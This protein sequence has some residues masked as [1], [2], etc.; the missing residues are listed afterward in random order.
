MLGPEPPPSLRS[1]ITGGGDEDK[2]G[3]IH[4]EDEMEWIEWDEVE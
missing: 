3:Y 4:D 1:K 2:L